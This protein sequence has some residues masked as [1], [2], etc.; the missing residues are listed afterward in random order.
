MKK[1]VNTGFWRPCSS[2][3]RRLSGAGLPMAANL[4]RPLREQLSWRDPCRRSLV[5]RKGCKAAPAIYA[6]KLKTWGALRTP[7]ATQGRSYKYSANLESNTPTEWPCQISRSCTK[8]RYRLHQGSRQAPLLYGPAN[9]F[10]PSPGGHCEQ[11][12]RPSTW[13]SQRHQG[14]VPA[15]AWYRQ[16]AATNVTTSLFMTPPAKTTNPFMTKGFAHTHSA[17]DH[18]AIWMTVCMMVLSVEM[19]LAFAW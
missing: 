16:K 3:E 7:F 17:S 13:L 2:R 14:A 5:S 6:A 10:Q 1:P 18:Q 8:G 12:R 11:T 4:Y 9:F 19:V 15:W